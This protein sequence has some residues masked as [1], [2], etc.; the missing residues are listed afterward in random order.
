[1]M[2]SSINK[3]SQ[4]YG[5]T[6]LL[7]AI[8]ETIKSGCYQPIFNLLFEYFKENSF[9]TKKKLQS[10]S[11]NAGCFIKHISRSY[12]LLETFVTL[13]LL[14]KKEKIRRE[15]LYRKINDN[16]WLHAKEALDGSRRDS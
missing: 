15:Y 11:I 3:P 9:I 5:E 13:N 4:P 12:Q 1:M 6:E 8:E 2:M 10:E 7:Y 16:L 14:V